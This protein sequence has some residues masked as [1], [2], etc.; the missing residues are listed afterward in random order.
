L[1]LL[2][3]DG[4]RA[5]AQIDETLP[6]DEQRDEPIKAGSTRRLV[7]AKPEHHAALV[8]LRDPEAREKDGEEDDEHKR[9][10]VHGIAPWQ[11]LRDRVNT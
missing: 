2:L 10:K 6:V 7:A 3:L 1:G 5:G 8:F 4:D 11:G 9:R